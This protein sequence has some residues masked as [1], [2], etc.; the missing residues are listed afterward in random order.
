VCGWVV[1]GGTSR[2]VG[3]LASTTV[4]WRVSI[5]CRVASCQAIDFRLSGPTIVM[6]AA[7]VAGSFQQCLFATNDQRLSPALSGR[8]MDAIR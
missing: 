6:V 8:Q 4:G 5:C 3:V 7:I 2:L 1:R